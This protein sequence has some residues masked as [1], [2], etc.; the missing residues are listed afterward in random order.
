MH[1]YC[2]SPAKSDSAIEAK[3]FASIPEYQV[4]IVDEPLN[5]NSPKQIETLLFDRLKLPEMKKSK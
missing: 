4:G 5:L 2:H 3:I 1:F